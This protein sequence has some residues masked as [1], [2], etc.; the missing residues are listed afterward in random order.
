MNLKKTLIA[1]V[2]GLALFAAPFA[3]AFTYTNGDVLL[4]F[5]S[6]G[7]HDIEFD[8][9]NVSQ[10][11]GRPNGYTNVVTNW[12]FSVVASNYSLTGNGAQFAVL[13]TT[14]ST[15]PNP[16]AWVS[17]SQP[18]VNVLDVTPSGWQNGLYSPI[19]ATGLGAANDPGAPTGT[20]YD[21]LSPTTH[22]AFDY[23]AS[24]NGN[25]PSEIPYLGGNAA[26]FKVTGA[27]PTTLL[28]YA[29]Q[30]SSTSPKPAATLIGSFSLN[31]AGVLVFQAGPVLDATT[32]TSVSTGNGNVPVTFNTKPAVKY[33]LIY[34]PA[35]P[36][37]LSN[38]VILPASIAGD[39]S[40]HTLIDTSPTNSS[41][42]YNVESYP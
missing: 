4:I 16:T 35:F 36:D 17:D 19:S 38:W 27:T 31:A 22:D 15:D 40:P 42:F 12:N 13:A 20:N 21:V 3:R 29:V 23:I 41:R 25:T 39:G 26:N 18:L 2:A 32:I 5:R 11:L 37:S 14:A 24:D 33:R 10:F 9:G 6:D 34:S 30:S 28:F 1:G 8:L 7:L